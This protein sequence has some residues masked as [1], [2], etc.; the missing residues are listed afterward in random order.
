A[1]LEIS[2]YPNPN[3]GSFVIKSE[4]IE[5]RDVVLEIFNEKGQLIWNRIIK[6]E[7][8]TLRESVDLGHSPDGLYLLRVRNNS[9]VRNKR[10]V[11][12]Y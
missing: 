6:D 12:S 2:L 9:G 1:E 5:M 11:I 10:F 8:G 3:N 4:M 7:V